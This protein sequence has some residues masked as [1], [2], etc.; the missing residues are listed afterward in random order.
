MKHEEL[1]RQNGILLNFVKPEF[2]TYELCYC[3]VE[4]NAKAIKYVPAEHID[5]AILEMVFDAGEQ[6]IRMVPK[7][8][9][10][11]CAMNTIKYQYPHIAIDMGIAP[12]IID[13]CDERE[14]IRNDYFDCLFSQGESVLM[15]LPTEYLNKYAVNKIKAA[16]PKLACDMD[17]L[18]IVLDEESLATYHHA[19]RIISD[20]LIF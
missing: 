7:S 6:F 17:L 1:I 15:C 16:Y 4:N 3:A 11:D 14:Y 12:M 18:D 8:S 5:D 19:L 10:T 2:R 13:G 20:D 9:L